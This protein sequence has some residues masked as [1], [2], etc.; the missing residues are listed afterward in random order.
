VGEHP[1]P[2]VE[3]GRCLGVVV[4]VVEDSA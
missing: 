1:D 4:V 2:L 3:H